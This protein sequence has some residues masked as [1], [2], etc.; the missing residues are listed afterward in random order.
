MTPNR[1]TAAEILAAKRANETMDNRIDGN[2][3]SGRFNNA[4]KIS[5]PFNLNIELSNLILIESSM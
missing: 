4:A 3:T 5:F 1:F 2:I